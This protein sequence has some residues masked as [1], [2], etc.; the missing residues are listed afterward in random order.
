MKLIKGSGLLLV[1]PPDVAKLLTAAR[2]STIRKSLID[3]LWPEGESSEAYR[4]KP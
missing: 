3:S 4:G 2:G 1:N